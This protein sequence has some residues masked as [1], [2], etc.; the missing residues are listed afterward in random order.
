MIRVIRYNKQR[1]FP[2]TPFID[3]II[4]G[5]PLLLFLVPEHRVFVL[6]TQHVSCEVIIELLNTI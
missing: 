4:F 1:L 6:N 2:Q 5:F 3:Y